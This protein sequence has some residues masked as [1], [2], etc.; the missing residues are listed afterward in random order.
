MNV[1]FDL[2]TYEKAKI[3][4]DDY[5][6]SNGNGGELDVSKV[7]GEGLSYDVHGEGSHTA[8]DSGTHND[9]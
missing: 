1:G 2:I 5:S 7:A 4:S 8:E 3:E 6:V 9:P